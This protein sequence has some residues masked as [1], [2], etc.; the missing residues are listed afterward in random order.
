[1]SNNYLPDCEFKLEYQNDKKEKMQS[2][3]YSLNIN[4]F[5]YDYGYNE[6]TVREEF[7]S[8]FNHFYD[9]L[10]EFKTKLEKEELNECIE[11]S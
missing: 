8:R 10:T 5:I 11:R 7:I 1:M 6:A 2:H 3:E 4:E 9:K